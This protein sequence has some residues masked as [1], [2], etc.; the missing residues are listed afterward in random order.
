MLVS[1]VDNQSTGT[2]RKVA[3]S[4]CTFWLQKQEKSSHT[5]TVLYRDFK[6]YVG[7]H[8]TNTRYGTV[9]TIYTALPGV[10]LVL[11]QNVPFD[12]CNYATGI[13]KR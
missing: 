5:K 9:R 8:S 12:S 13:F 7:L 2:V 11:N 10:C 4:Y 3:W 6:K 1:S